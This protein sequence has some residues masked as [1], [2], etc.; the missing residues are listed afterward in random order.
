[1]TSTMTIC[2]YCGSSS[3]GPDSHRAAAR[4][5]GRAMAD[6]GM[7]LVYGGGRV[8]VM[9]TLADSVMTAGGEAIG[10]IPRFLM[11]AE[12]GNTAL[13]RLEVV[14]TMHERKARMAELSDAFAVLPGG[15]GTMEELFE[16][17]T[18]R[19]LGL[20][21]KPIV[22]LNA[23]RYWDRLRAV[24]D[25]AIAENYARPETARLMRFVDEPADAIA[26]LAEAARRPT[27][28]DAGRL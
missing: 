3:R 15:L 7:R 19:Q 21:D 1:M 26:F 16:I 9:G 23:G 24:L 13:T 14:E 27:H 6:R 10:V 20:H 12:V 4:T 25:Q 28:L 18:W 22:V 17:V 5:F 11:E 2:V 8:G